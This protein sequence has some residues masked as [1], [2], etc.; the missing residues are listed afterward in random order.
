MRATGVASLP[1]SLGSVGSGCGSDSFAAGTKASLAVGAEAADASSPSS[2]RIAIAVP[3]FTPSVPS[4]IRIFAMTPSSTASN[5]IV[6]LSVSI[7]A[8]MSLDFTASP[9]LTSHLASVP[10]SIVG[11]NAGILISIDMRFLSIPG[12]AFSRPPWRCGQGAILA[13]VEPPRHDAAQRGTPMRIYLVVVDESPESSIALRFAARRAVKTGGGVEILTI[14]PPAEFMA[15]GGIQATIEEEARL[16]AE[17]LVAAAAGTIIEESGLRPSITVR[18]G[19]APTIVRT[20]IAGKPDI[21]ALVL[22]AAATG[23]P[24]ALV[25]HFAVADAGV[26]TVPLMIV[27]G[28]L[29]REQI[30]RLS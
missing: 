2:A 16:H 30:D 10:S 22:G 8:M 12:A 18:E 27:P 7:S 19:D 24:G 13:P 28:S 14:L 23:A 9:S 21:A 5:S 29:T 11:D 3:T 17:G 15:F 26:L 25:T 1:V 20:L 4:A 6:A